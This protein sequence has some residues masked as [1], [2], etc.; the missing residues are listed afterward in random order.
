MVTVSRSNTSLIDGALHADASEI[1]LAPGE[2]PEII[3]VVDDLQRGDLF[4]RSTRTD[5]HGELLG[6]SYYSKQGALL[7]VWND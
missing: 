7:R 6:Y 3:A 4:H 1:D 5:I 2:W